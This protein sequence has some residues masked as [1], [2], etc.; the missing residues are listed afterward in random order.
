MTC[1]NSKFEVVQGN[2]S[3]CKMGPWWIFGRAQGGPHSE[4]KRVFGALAGSQG[5]LGTQVHVHAGRFGGSGVA[6]YYCEANYK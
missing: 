3:F 4:S 1:N 2:I 6:I 5:A